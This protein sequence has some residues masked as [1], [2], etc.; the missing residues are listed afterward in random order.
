MIVVCIDMLFYCLLVACEV[1]ER[2]KNSTVF[3]ATSTWCE[4]ENSNYVPRGEKRD[5]RVTDGA[6]GIKVNTESS[7]NEEYDNA[8][9][10]T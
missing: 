8:L 9:S 6:T 1:Q 4:D 3:V 10:S 5:S 7:A 2:G